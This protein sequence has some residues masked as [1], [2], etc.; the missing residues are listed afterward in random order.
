MLQ[1]PRR[2]PHDAVAGELQVRIPDPVAFERATAAME[3]VAV[4][5][6]DH[7]LSSPKRVDGSA[8]DIY[9]ESGSWQAVR[10]AE[11]DEP[12]LELGA[13]VRGFFSVREQRG[14]RPTA[15]PAG[16]PIAERA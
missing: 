15:A 6:H 14:Y 8:L 5:F 16:A 2:D 4:D 9:V 13:D 3:G 11:L 10:T 7:V 12:A 1:P